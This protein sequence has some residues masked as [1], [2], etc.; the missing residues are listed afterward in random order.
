MSIIK[1]AIVELSELELEVNGLIQEA[2][3][4]ERIDPQTENELS[5]LIEVLK[6]DLFVSIE[7]PYV[8]KV[9]RDSY[10]NYFASKH[11]E[12]YRDCVRLCFFDEQIGAEDFRSVAGFEKLQK[13]FKGYVVI[14][15]TFPNIIGRTLL[16]KSAFLESNFITC[17]YKGNALVNG[18]KLEVEGFPYS[19]QDTESIS[20]AE[21]TIWALME[22]FGNRY[23]D[24]RPTL[25]ST[26]VNFLNK[27]SKQRVLPS[28]GLT[29]EQISV[30]LKEFGFG[31]FIYSGED[32]YEEELADIISTYI[33]SGIPIVA[34]L[35]ND[36]IG[37]AILIIGRADKVTI[38]AN[39]KRREF[40]F[41]TEE[42][43]YI[44]FNDI[45]KKYVVQDDNL[46]PYRQVDL[47][48]PVEHYTDKDEGFLDCLIQSIVVPLYKKIYIE[49]VKAKQQVI[50]IAGDLHFGYKFEPNFIFRFFLTSSRSFKHHVSSLTSIDE[51]IKNLLIL[52]TMPKFIW[53]GEF[54]SKKGFKKNLVAGLIVVDATEAR[55]NKRD[56]LIFAGYPDRCLFKVEKDFGILAKSFDFYSTFTNNLR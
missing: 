27:H 19:S 33:E 25:P 6:D 50:K 20:C 48:W 51:E 55:E 2:Y 38:P 54:Y 3:D 10:Y 35:E 1:F 8:D 11:N 46:P 14:R 12:Y 56:S 15:P 22:Y 39:Q 9:Y 17:V 28:N 40:K 53:C 5:Y 32:S 45:K 4:I 41:G 23:P 37:H 18:A 47:N 16:H 43:S 49:A 7:Y 42:I 26:I 24:Y 34:A 44:D 30:A 52:S 29:V 21:T 36:T 13:A 31:T